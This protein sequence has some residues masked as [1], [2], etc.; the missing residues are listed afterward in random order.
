MTLFFY[1]PRSWARQ[2]DVLLSGKSIFSMTFYV[3]LSSITDPPVIG[4]QYEKRSSQ[5]FFPF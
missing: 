2:D 4:D 1:F 5:D 3:Q